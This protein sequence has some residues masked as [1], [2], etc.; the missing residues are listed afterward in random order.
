MLPDLTF[1]DADGHFLRFFGCTDLRIGA[2]RA[3]KCEGLDFKV[4][5]SVDPPKSAQKGEKQF[6]RT[7]IFALFFSPPKIEMSGIV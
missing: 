6:S 5:S 4:H 1:L 7:K 3:K 2:S